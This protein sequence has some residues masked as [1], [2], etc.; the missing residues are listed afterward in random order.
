MSPFVTFDTSYVPHLYAK[1]LISN[2]AIS[3]AVALSW[4]VVL[5]LPLKLVFRLVVFLLSLLL[6]SRRWLVHKIDTKFVLA[7]FAEQRSERNFTLR[8]KLYII[9]VTIF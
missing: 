5:P 2:F 6:C 7:L 9:V 1:G 3:L 8:T 4:S